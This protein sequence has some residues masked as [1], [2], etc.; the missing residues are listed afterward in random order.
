MAATSIHT[1]HRYLYLS[2]L[3]LLFNLEFKRAVL[4]L[5]NRYTNVFVIRPSPMC[6]FSPY[7]V[8]FLD[9]ATLESVSRSG[10]MK[11]GASIELPLSANC[12]GNIGT[13]MSA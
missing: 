2:K 10:G 7:F 12:G 8:D 5:A 13:C 4:L 9:G 3:I 1:H 6:V 11:H